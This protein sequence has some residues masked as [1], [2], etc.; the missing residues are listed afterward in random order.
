MATRA[1]PCALEHLLDLELS[2]SCRCTLGDVVRDL[3]NLSRARRVL[4]KIAGHPYSAE[5]RKA[6]SVQTPGPKERHVIF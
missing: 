1:T 4:P 3:K 6:K 2:A 5:L